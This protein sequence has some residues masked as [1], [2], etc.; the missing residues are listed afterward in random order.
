MILLVS[1]FLT[2]LS[3]LDLVQGHGHLT[4]PRSRNWV[5]SPQQ[6]GTWNSIPGVPAAE[7]CPHCLNRK[8]PDRLCGIG[9]AGDYDEW[10]DSSGVPMTWQSQGVLRLG[11]EFDVTAF[12]DTNHAG[13]CRV[14]GRVLLAIDALLPDNSS[15]YG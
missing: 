15:F 9:N 13:R 3:F 7:S 6:E 5:A 14:S 11:E 8:L 2:I 1:I 10:L 12:L 4:T